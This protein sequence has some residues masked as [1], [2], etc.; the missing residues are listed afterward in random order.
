M[1]RA[2]LIAPVGLG[3]DRP[4]TVANLARN[5]AG[6]GGH[7]AELWATTRRAAWQLLDRHVPW[8]AR[9]AVVG[10]GNGDDLPL[11]R[12]AA[13]ASRLDLFD[14]D[15]AALRRARRSCPPELR[16]RVRLHRFDVTAGAADRI[17][18]AVRLARQPGR[19]DVPQTPLG[20]GDYDVVIGDLFY[21]QLLYP[22][23]LDAGL[24][25]VRMRPVLARYGPPL[26]DAVV[27]RM[28]ASAAPGAPVIHL[29]D[30][31]GWWEGHPQPVSLPEILAQSGLQDA[32]TL[33]SR[34]RRPVGTDPRESAHRLG[35]Q[36]VDTA[37]WEWPFAP[38][39]SYLVCATVTERCTPGQP[40][41]MRWLHCGRTAR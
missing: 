6:G 27:A 21:S 5:A 40:A 14:L 3:R 22:A 29:H 4:A 11:V 26:T 30:V 19:R 41:A 39:V 37:L 17:T 16:Q 15:A 32:V 2:G 35:A 8:D 7:R 31:A 20:Q 38:A 33:I 18:R 1:S 34:C 28:H 10:A 13:R 12:L 25:R 36:V 24:S 9:V 23:L